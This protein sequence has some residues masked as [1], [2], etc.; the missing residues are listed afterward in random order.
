M[1]FCEVKH[2]KRFFDTCSLL[3]D[4]SDLSDVILSSKTIEE[5]ENIKTS[6]NKDSAIKYKARKAVRAI[7]SQNPEVIIVNKNDYL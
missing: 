5:L 4:C 2:M 6:Y 1:K 3:T 7:K